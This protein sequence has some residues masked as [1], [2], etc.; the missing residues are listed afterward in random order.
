[1]SHQGESK[2]QEFQSFLKRL[3]SGITQKLNYN[4]NQE[5]NRS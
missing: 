1:M 3:Q 2:L 4:R 5:G